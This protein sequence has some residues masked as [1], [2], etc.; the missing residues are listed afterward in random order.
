[1]RLTTITM[2][3]AMMAQEAG[4]T[5]FEGVY[6]RDYQRCLRPASDSRV[7]FS[8]DL[9][10]FWEGGCALSNPTVIRDMPDARLY[11]GDCGEED[12]RFRQRI[13]VMR[14]DRRYEQPSNADLAI[15]R[16]G[17]VAFYTTCPPGTTIYGQ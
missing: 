4:A 12:Y 7:V 13:M 17:T 14:I 16:N 15:I 10:E 9:M 1:M 2:G 5:P 6:D 3:A 8:G 11:D